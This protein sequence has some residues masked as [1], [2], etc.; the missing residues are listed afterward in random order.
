MLS[1][2]NYT[3]RYHLSSL[4]STLDICVCVCS[5]PFF[6]FITSIFI[7]PS[8]V[9]IFFFLAMQLYA[10]F[11][12]SILLL[13]ISFCSG[14]MALYY[15]ESN[16]MNTLVMLVLSSVADDVRSRRTKILPHTLIVRT[17][18]TCFFL[19]F[20]RLL[21]S[22]HS[23]GHKRPVAFVVC[24]FSTIFFFSPIF[25]IHEHTSSIPFAVYSRIVIAIAM[26]LYNR[27]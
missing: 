4:N 27:F 20:I 12:S 15:P 6:F 18:A 10:T 11:I 7:P 3:P 2:C 19:S 23:A 14:C 22:I 25:A 13:Y 26:R 5:C 8:V 1:V 24:S 21:F 17:K 16:S 9:G